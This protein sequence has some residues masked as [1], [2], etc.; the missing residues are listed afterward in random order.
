[1]KR[2]Y[3]KGYTIILTDLGKH[4]RDWSEDPWEYKVVGTSIKDEC[5]GEDEAFEYAK[6]EIDKL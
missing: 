6:E 4:A 2:K 5:E 3:Y 1:M